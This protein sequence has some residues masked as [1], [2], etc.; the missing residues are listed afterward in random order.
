MGVCIYDFCYCQTT[1][2]KLFSSIVYKPP[3]IIKYNFFKKFFVVYFSIS[4]S[5]KT[6]NDNFDTLRSEIFSTRKFRGMYFRDGL[7]KKFE[8]RRI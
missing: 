1:L 3:I 5:K 2:V 6:C 4:D 7:L 8:L